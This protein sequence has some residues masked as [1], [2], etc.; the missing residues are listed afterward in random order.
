MV[1]R[2]ENWTEEFCIHLKSCLPTKVD[3][4]ICRINWISYVENVTF[5]L[6]F[7]INEPFELNNV[8]FPRCITRIKSV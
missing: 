7:E 5:L 6:T 3:V 1:W 8:P 4:Y 2:L